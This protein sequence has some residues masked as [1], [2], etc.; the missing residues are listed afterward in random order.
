MDLSKEL[1]KCRLEMKGP[2]LD[3]EANRQ[4]RQR[5]RQARKESERQ[6]R[7]AHTKQKKVIP[8]PSKVQE[9]EEEKKCGQSPG[10]SSGSSYE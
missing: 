3:K 9:A 2:Y 4:L 5:Q 7:E 10:V 1:E 8:V 6:D